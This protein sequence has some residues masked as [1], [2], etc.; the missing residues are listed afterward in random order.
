L[1][2]VVLSIGGSILIPGDSDTAYIKELSKM[3][4]GASKMHKIYVVVGGGKTAREYI[5]IGRELGSDESYLDDIGIDTTRL[6]ARL[7]IAGLSGHAPPTPPKNFDDAV[8]L[9]RNY[10]I[11]VMGG[12][13]PGHTTDAVSAML[14]ERIRA[15]KLINATSVDGVY[16]SDPKKDKSAKKIN[17]MTFKELMEIVFKSEGVA[18]QN[19]V[20]DALATKLIA[21]SKITTIVLNGRDLASLKNAIE[22]KDFIGTVISSA[23]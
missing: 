11:V 18:G 17:K 22:G 9:G 2:T 1:D 12:T 13:H 21:R 15:D 4:I 10:P 20:F 14:A 5:K 3:L 6:N 8:H 19:I 7:L 23:V 16:T